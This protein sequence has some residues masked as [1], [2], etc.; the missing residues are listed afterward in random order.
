MEC[1][2]KK[3]G[4]KAPGTGHGNFVGRVPA[5]GLYLARDLNDSERLKI[6]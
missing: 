1:Q 5:G 2:D 6:F 4:A 3:I